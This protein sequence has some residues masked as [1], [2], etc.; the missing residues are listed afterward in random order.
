MSSDPNTKETS[1]T[2]HPNS[3]SRWTIIAWIC[4]AWVFVGLCTLVSAADDLF[5]YDRGNYTSKFAWIDYMIYSIL[6]AIPI[7][8]GCGLWAFFYRKDYGLALLPT[9]ILG[10]L[11]IFLA[12][13]TRWS[14]FFN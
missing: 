11:S 4:L 8:F 14:A 2:I 1:E 6:A 7:G 9:L 5:N 3:G 12:L 13:T 10:L